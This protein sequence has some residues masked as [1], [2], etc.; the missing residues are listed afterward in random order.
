MF[1][2]PMQ[3]G[4][5]N[6]RLELRTQD[7]ALVAGSATHI[8]D[9]SSGEIYGMRFIPKAPLTIGRRYE[10]MIKGGTE[11]IIAEDGRSMPDDYRWTFT[12]VQRPADPA[13]LAAPPEPVVAVP[14]PAEGG[15]AGRM[16]THVYL[17][18]VVR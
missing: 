11:G 14:P 2:T 4:A 12:V 10:V 18:L 5:L 13:L 7:G 15:I 16:G 1:A 9:P 17:P 3:A 8:V 6:Q